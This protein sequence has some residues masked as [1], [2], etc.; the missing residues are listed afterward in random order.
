MHAA[1]SATS[2]AAT[3][4]TTLAHL[5]G[6]PGEVDVGHRL[7]P[8]A[9][10]ARGYR[11]RHLRLRGAL[12]TLLAQV[13]GEHGAAGG[14]VVLVDPH[15]ATVGHPHR[16]DLDRDARRMGAVV[17]ARADLAAG[18]ARRDPSRSTSSS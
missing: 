4:S 11:Q 7:D 14:V 10:A 6:A 5:R 8:R 1:I 3:S 2:R 18:D 16:P 13:G 17:L 9:G 15:L 12:A